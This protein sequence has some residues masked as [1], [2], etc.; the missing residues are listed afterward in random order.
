MLA[1]D[2]LCMTI[3]VYTSSE[4]RFNILGVLSILPIIGHAI[5]VFGGMC[6]ITSEWFEFRLW[7]WFV[8]DVYRELLCVLI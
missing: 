8:V 6:S 4:I 5:S 1:L 3:Y 7:L 2:L